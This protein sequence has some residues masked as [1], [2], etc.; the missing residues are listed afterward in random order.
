[1][2]VAGVDGVFAAVYDGLSVQRY[3]MYI[4][5]MC[6]TSLSQFFLL[7]GAEDDRDDRGIN[8]ASLGQFVAPGA[9]T[10]IEEICRSRYRPAAL[11][12][13]MAMSLLWERRNFSDHLDSDDG[14]GEAINLPSTWLWQLSQS[15]VQ[16]PSRS[17]A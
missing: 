11:L 7:Y 2:P 4:L 12:L 16:V 8:P 6:R 10:K 15:R 1:M 13:V 3:G 9:N 17:C 14:G 5:A